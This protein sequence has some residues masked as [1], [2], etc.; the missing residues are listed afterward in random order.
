LEITN[1]K[2]LFDTLKLENNLTEFVLESIKR[3]KFTSTISEDEDIPETYF[4]MCNKITNT[5]LFREKALSF[6]TRHLKKA[7]IFYDVVLD[8]KEDMLK[9]SSVKEAV[10][11]YMEEKIIDLLCHFMERIISN[12]FVFN[13][14]PKACLVFFKRMENTKIL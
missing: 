13:F 5:D 2:D 11:R 8:N 4:L 10:I 14:D 7:K 1:C 3:F 12:N 9:C 6:I